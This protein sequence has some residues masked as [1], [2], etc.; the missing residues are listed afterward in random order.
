[1]SPLPGLKFYFY[2]A[3]YRHL[4][5]SGANGAWISY[6]YSQLQTLH[7]Y[8][9][10]HLGPSGAGQLRRVAPRGGD[11]FTFVMTG[12]GPFG[13]KGCVSRSYAKMNVSTKGWKPLPGHM[14]PDGPAF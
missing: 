5:P 6:D 14:V 13:V 10:R 4:G 12:P 3:L 7:P 11:G 9:V 8:G 1:M 2:G